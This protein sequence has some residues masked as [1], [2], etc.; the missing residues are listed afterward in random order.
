MS[1]GDV[2]ANEWRGGE[3]PEKWL[4]VADMLSPF[5]VF[6]RSG[7]FVFNVDLVQFLKYCGSEVWF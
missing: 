4:I 1:C 5:A 6:F 2:S 3:L 7:S